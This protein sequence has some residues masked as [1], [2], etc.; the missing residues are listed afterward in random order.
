MNKRKKGTLGENKA[1]RLLEKRGYAILARN[2]KTR[3]GEIDIIAYKNSILMF[4]EVKV[5]DYF[6][7]DCLEY[8]IGPRKKQRIKMTS[9][10]FIVNNP[11]YRESK[12]RFD[13]IIF[14]DNFQTVEH[15]KNAF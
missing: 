8:L 15:L 4:I 13:V 2:Y 12:M 11:E 7:Q 5:I 14:Q 9:Q 6:D 3:W 10:Y 1:V